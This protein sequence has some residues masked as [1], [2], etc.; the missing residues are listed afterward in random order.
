M[1]SEKSVF[2]LLYSVRK[3]SFFTSYID[4]KNSIFSPYMTLGKL[5][6]CRLY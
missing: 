4:S 6:F 3:V 2:Y 5:G 1:Q